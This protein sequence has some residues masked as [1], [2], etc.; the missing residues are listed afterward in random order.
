MPLSGFSE[1]SDPERGFQLWADIAPVMIRTLG[2]G[3]LCDW[4][5]RH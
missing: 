2:P 1:T 5:N 4:F 3:K